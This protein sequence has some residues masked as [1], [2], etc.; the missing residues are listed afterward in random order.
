MAGGH[1]FA[2]PRGVRMS[3]SDILDTPLFNHPL[4]KA[5]VAEDFYSSNINELY[6]PERGGELS[7]EIQSTWID[8]FLTAQPLG[9]SCG[10]GVE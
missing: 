1:L 9:V 6:H 7:K 10:P 2:E 3:N 5:S 8:E 4:R